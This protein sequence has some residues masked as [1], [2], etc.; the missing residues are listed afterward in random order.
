MRTR[1]QEDNRVVIVELTQSGSALAETN[2]IAGIG[3]LRRRLP[4]FP[5]NACKSSMKPSLTS[6]S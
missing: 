5:K 4:T 3:L 6:C 2:A 1:S